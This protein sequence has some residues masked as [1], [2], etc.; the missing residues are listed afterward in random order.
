MDYCYHCSDK[1]L[2]NKIAYKDKYFCCAA[3]KTVFQIISSNQLGDYYV[4]DENPGIKPESKS[5]SDFSYLVDSIALNLFSYRDDKLAIVKLS[6][7]DIHCSSCIWLLENIFKLNQGIKKVLVNF[8][9]REATIHFHHQEI[10]LIELADLLQKIGYK[11]SISLQNLDNPKKDI[12]SKLIYQIAIAGFAFGNTMFLGFTEYFDSQGD[13]PQSFLTFFGAIAFSLS[14]PV[15]FYSA[16][17]YFISAW[18]GLKSRFINIDVP[19]SIGIITLFF[20]SSFDVYT[21]KG[22]GYF[23]SLT[24]LVFFLLLGKLFQNKTYHKLSFDRD[25]KSYFPI[26]VLKIIF[27]SEESTQITLLQIGDLI[28]VKNQ[29]IIPCD[30]ILIQ[31]DALIDNSFITGESKE[32]EALKGDFIYAGAKNLGK[33]ILLEVKKEVSQSYL[34]ELW[35]QEAFSKKH[36]SIDGLINKVSKYF[37]LSV[38]SIALVAFIYWYFIDPSKAIYVVSAVLIVACPCALALSSPFTLGSALRLMGAKGFYLKNGAVIE[39]LAKTNHIVFDKTGT[40]T[41][42]N[43][44]TI[45]YTGTDLSEYLKA[46]LFT[47]VK[48]SSHPISTAIQKL[49]KNSNELLVTDYKE[50]PGKGISAKING[51]TIKLGSTEFITLKSDFNNSKTFFQVDDKTIGYFK[52]EHEFRKNL[53][54]LFNQL[55]SNYQISVLSGDSNYAEEKLRNLVPNNSKLLFKQQPIQKLN[56]I[57]DLQNNTSKVL[58]IGDGLNDA[59]ALKQAD[60][61]I[62]ISDN[63]NSFSPASD[64]ILDANSFSGLVKF[65]CFSRDCIKIIKISFAISWLYNCIGL[66]FAVQGLLSPVIA[67]ILMPLSSISVVAFTSISTRIIAKLR[68]I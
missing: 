68:K 59:G 14:L 20:Q 52:I 3:C 61:G 55:S 9:K 8:T 44:N 37:T 23:D 24:G 27:N 62:S 1:L 28:R 57:K 25:Y 54:T 36:S 5:K 40:L 39:Q 4:F 13:L 63:L 60:L 65:M 32:I 19:I 33:S 15:V 67:A 64:A 46:C 11:P 47:L 12:D 49:F 50:I 10:S 35:N 18:K 66:F 48:Q 29:E 26:S 6:L 45:T 16:Q 34:T 30:C 17:D 21:H 41:Q 2:N 38:L 31:S 51:S 43:E 42:K 53:K 58:M 7:P 22:L 56:Y